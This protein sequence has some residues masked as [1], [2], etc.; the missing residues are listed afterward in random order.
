MQENYNSDDQNSINYFD[1]QMELSLPIDSAYDPIQSEIMPSEVFGR[2]SNNDGIDFDSRLELNQMLSELKPD[3]P[4]TPVNSNQQAL[5][6]PIQF[7][8]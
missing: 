8:T 5:V 2:I 1:S 7:L 6:N 4:M 3:V